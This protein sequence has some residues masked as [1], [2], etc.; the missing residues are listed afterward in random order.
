MGAGEP[1]EMSTRRMT[2]GRVNAGSL[3]C[4]PFSNRS[5][6]AA[7]RIRAGSISLFCRLAAID[8]PEFERLPTP[9]LWRLGG[10][11]SRALGTGA[12]AYAFLASRPAR[13]LRGDSLQFDS[14]TISIAFTHA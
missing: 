11:V 5:Q 7:R 14:S 9:S 4:F 12:S 6:P 10:L 13:C 2:A 1:G 3:P 8:G